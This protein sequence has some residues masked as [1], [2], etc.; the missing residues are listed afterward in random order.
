MLWIYAGPYGSQ[1]VLH[2]DYKGC[3]VGE[4]RAGVSH[5]SRSQTT[6]LNSLYTLGFQ[7]I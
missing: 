4:A 6:N 7:M 5:K 3:V 1:Q 2:P